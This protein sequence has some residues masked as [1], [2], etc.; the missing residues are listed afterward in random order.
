MMDNFGPVILLEVVLV[1][2]GILLFVWWQLRDLKK[3][4]EKDQKKKA[5]N[6]ELDRQEC[7]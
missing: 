1:F 2:G 6:T 5:Q 4:Q 7:K 3:E